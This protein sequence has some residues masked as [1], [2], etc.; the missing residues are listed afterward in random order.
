MVEPFGF[1]IADFG[2]N[3]DTEHRAVEKDVGDIRSLEK[4][5]AGSVRKRLNRRE[6]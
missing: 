2:I 1:W 3:T 4:H 6:K 5:P